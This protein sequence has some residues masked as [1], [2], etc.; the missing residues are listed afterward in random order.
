[1]KD[2]EGLSGRYAQ[3]ALR[4]VHTR[5][6]V[7]P[8]APLEAHPDPDVPGANYVDGLGDARYWV[9]LQGEVVR[10]GSDGTPPT[11][12]EQFDQAHHRYTAAVEKVRLRYATPVVERLFAT[13]D[14][15]VPDAFFVHDTHEPQTV[16]WVA[17]DGEVHDGYRLVDDEARWDEE[18]AAARRAVLRRQPST[19]PLVDG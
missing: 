16:R 5:D 18:T 10:T 1:M 12:S 15:H 4:K 6:D 8:D 17:P 3:E 11:R 7:P 9:G 19:A 14:T 13:P 2:P